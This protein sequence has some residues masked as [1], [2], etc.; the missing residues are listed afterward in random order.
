MK[1]LFSSS[2]LSA[3]KVVSSAYLRL[4]IFLP[5]I[6]ISACDSFNPECHIMYSA[7]KLNKQ[8]DNMQPWRTP[9]SIWNQPVVPCSVLP[10]ASW[11][12]YKF[13]KWQVRWSGI[14]F[15]FRIFHSVLIHIT[16]VTSLKRLVKQQV[17]GKQC[18]DDGWHV[19][20]LES[21][22]PAGRFCGLYE[23]SWEEGAATWHR[24][25]QL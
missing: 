13:F 5:I 23:G 19:F 3:I 4:L 18:R 15:S 9:F 16:G 7:Y 11:P 1:R 21:W 22:N 24:T 2:S 8:G 10:V 17:E 6:L 12:A 20:I 25:S 14:T